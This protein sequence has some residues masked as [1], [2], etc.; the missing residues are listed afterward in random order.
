MIWTFDVTADRDLTEAEIGLMDTIPAIYEGDITPEYGGKQ[1]VVF[2][3]DIAAD[4]IETAVRD[5]V[6]VIRRIGVKPMDTILPV[7]ELIG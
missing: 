4:T 5:A 3:C 2:H 1:P 7:A 6:R